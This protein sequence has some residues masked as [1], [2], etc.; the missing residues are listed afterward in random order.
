L[1]EYVQDQT[2][3]IP[4]LA[5]ES[6]WAPYGI[7]ITDCGIKTNGPSSYSVNFEEWTSPSDGAPSTIETVATSSTYEAEDNGAMTDANIAAGSIVGIDLPTT[8][9]VEWLQVWIT[10][11]VDAS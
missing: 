9:G 8:A 3:F 1:P 10:Y 11:T 4:L 7:T 2:D 6:S 5:V